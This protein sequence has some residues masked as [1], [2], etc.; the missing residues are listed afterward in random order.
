MPAAL[1]GKLKALYPNA[2]YYLNFSTP[3]E[4]LV[5]AIL[6]AQVRDTVVN[7]TTPA[8]FK[9][10]RS[11]DEYARADL[12]TLTREIKAITFSANK[13]KHIKQ[14]CAILD[15]KYHGRVPE[16]LEQL[17]ELPGIGRKTAHAILI[18][19]F[20]KVEGVVVD[21]HVIR[22]AFRLGWT[23]NT[24]PDKIEQDL[25][26]LIPKADWAK[27]TWLLKDHGRAVCSAP[28]PAC[29]RCALEPDCPKAGVTKRT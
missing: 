10:Y 28:V 12:E 25:M 19:A 29:S 8:L 22:V 3:L 13:A 17:V 4:L 18:N 7:A 6:S 9:K 26:T 27:A 15:E 11:A 5:A 23:K 16:T 24:K 14:A 20:G 1:L 21:T 2:R